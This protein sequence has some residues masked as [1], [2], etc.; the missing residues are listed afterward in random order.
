MGEDEEEEESQG[1]N[2]EEIKLGEQVNHS[3]DSSIPEVSLHALAGQ[4]NPRTIRVRG[5]IDNHYVNVL[6]DSGSTHNFIQER[7]A[8]QLGL[9]IILSKH[10]KVYVGNGDF[11]ICDSKC[12]NVQLCVQGHKFVMDLF[13]LPVQGADVVLEIQWL[14]LLGPVVTDYK[15]LTMTFQ[16]R[17]KEVQLID[18]SQISESTN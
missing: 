7:I 14:E 16:W 1:M 10:F 13:I 3:I 17:G 8:K 18:E 5:R 12:V 6:V 2:S 11:L 15:L 9:P 4:Y